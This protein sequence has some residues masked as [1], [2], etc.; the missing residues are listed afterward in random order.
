M[1]SLCYLNVLHIVVDVNIF[2][3]PHF[4]GLPL[5]MSCSANII[6]HTVA[7]IEYIT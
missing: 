1:E 6:T 2:G 3:K 4:E 5:C 7:H